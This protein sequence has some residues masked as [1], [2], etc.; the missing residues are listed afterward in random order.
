MKLVIK[1]PFDIINREHSV[2]RIHLGH[3]VVTD[4]RKVRYPYPVPIFKIS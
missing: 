2:E 3:R 1:T 4:E